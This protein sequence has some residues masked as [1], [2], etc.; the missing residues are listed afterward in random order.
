MV[1]IMFGWM[2]SRRRMNGCRTKI[3]M[4]KIILSFVFSWVLQD[5]KKHCLEDKHL[6]NESCLD[7]ASERNNHCIYIS[8]DDDDVDDSYSAT[9]KLIYIYFSIL[10]KKEYYDSS[11]SCMILVC[12]V[13][14]YECTMRNVHFY[15]LFWLPLVSSQ[16]WVLCF[17]WVP[18]FVL[19]LVMFTIFWAPCKTFWGI[20]VA[21]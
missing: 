7:H 15:V 6:P 21:N 10:V 1:E 14:V 16:F 12:E 8:D 18:G 3:E 19:A 20:S 2:E 4:K 13:L 5:D 17:S 11:D 9:V